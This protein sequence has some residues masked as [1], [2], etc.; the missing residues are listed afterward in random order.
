MQCHS[1]ERL[2]TLQPTFGPCTT[3]LEEIRIRCCCAAKKAIED[4][5]S[6][7]ESSGRRATRNSLPVNGNEG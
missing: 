6:A 7:F 5:A 2:G 3:V 4:G 1:A